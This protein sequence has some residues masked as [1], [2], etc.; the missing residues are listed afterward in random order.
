MGV[1][2]VDMSRYQMALDSKGKVDF[3]KMYA[4]GIRGVIFRAI[5]CGT[6]TGEIGKDWRLD[7][8][9]RWL[10]EYNAA[11]PNEQILLVGYYGALRLERDIAAQAEAMLEAV[12]SHPKA[13]LW[14]DVE[15]AAPYG[16]T[17]FQAGLN[18]YDWMINV[19]ATGIYTREMWF[20]EFIEQKA[21]NWSQWELW[22]ARYPGMVAWDKPV[23]GGP[24]ADGKYKFLS[25]DEYA[26]WQYGTPSVGKMLGVESEEIDVNDF[27]G[28]EAE[29]VTWVTGEE[30]QPAPAATLIVPAGKNIR[31]TPNGVDCGDTQAASGLKILREEDAGG[32][33]WYVVE[34]SVAQTS[35]VVKK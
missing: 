28:T 21:F 18:L 6:A 30:P 27:P 11:N 9:V 31:V 13:R 22:P 33:H 15:G 16:L 19:D 5:V 23:I 4:N 8:Y 14:A 25:W 3:N 10:G 7:D 1:K 34:V 26:L 17:L 29:F 20:D 12:A 35:G 24:W 2:I 32:Y